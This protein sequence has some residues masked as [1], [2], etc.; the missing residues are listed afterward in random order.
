[1]INYARKYDFEKAATIRDFIQEL[2][3]I[4]NIL[5]KDNFIFSY[6]KLKGMK[7]R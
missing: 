1:M 2:K 6:L 5:M 3:N 4:K 7:I